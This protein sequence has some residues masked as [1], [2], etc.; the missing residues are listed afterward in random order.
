MQNCMTYRLLA[1]NAVRKKETSTPSERTRDNSSIA[2][3]WSLSILLRRDIALLS[4]RFLE[5]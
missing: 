4:V 5:L 3:V 1:V 2:Y